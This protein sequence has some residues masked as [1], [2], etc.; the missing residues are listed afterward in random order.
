[1]NIADALINEGNGKNQLYLPY[2][3]DSKWRRLTFNIENVATMTIGCKY[4]C[5][6]DNLRGQRTRSLPEP[7]PLAL[8]G[9]GI[10]GILAVRRRRA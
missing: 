6:I 8:L 10:V 9:L 3:G 7:A 1:M 2:T 5:A 4:E